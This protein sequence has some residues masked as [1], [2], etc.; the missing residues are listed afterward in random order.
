MLLDGSPAVSVS[1][2]SQSAD[3]PTPSRA[4]GPEHRYRDASDAER[5]RLEVEIL[6]SHRG[7]LIWLVRRLLADRRD[8][9][10]EA[11]QVGEI[12]MWESLQTFDPE[13]G[14]KFWTF[15]SWRVQHAVN[16]WRGHG[17]DWAPRGRSG[18]ARSERD[19]RSREAANLRK[20]HAPLAD[21][22]PFASDENVEELV[23]NAEGLALVQRFLATLSEADRH[24]VTCENRHHGTAGDNARKR[25]QRA[26]IEQARAY[27]LGDEAI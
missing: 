24:L 16:T 25:R 8:Q 23:A 9:W 21:D 3:P 11:R 22:P 2:D 5:R 6:A 18:K 13:R 10:G 17:V 12:A 26:L 1:F 27:V 19:A 7:R 4:L 15:A 14:V 20:R